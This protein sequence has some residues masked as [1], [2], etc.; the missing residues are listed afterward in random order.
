MVHRNQW[1]G[2]RE[3]ASLQVCKCSW[4]SRKELKVTY[5]I[6]TKSGPRNSFHPKAGKD[7]GCHIL[8]G[9]TLYVHSNTTLPLLPYIPARWSSSRLHVHLG[10]AVVANLPQVL[11]LTQLRPLQKANYGGLIMPLF[12]FVPQVASAYRWAEGTSLLKATLVWS[13]RHLTRFC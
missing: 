3:A 8:F 11:K 1:A 2:G 12:F 4:Q 13:L 5:R 10:R 6:C 9:Y 7:G